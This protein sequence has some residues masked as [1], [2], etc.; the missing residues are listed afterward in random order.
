M[1]ITHGLDGMGQARYGRGMAVKAWKRR[2]L[3]A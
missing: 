3:T 1:T 2:S